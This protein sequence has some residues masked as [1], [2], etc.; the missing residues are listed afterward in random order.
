MT[1]IMT[2]KELQEERRRFRERNGMEPEA[3]KGWKDGVMAGAVIVFI[4]GV[5]LSF[6]IPNHVPMGTF[7][8][9]ASWMIPVLLMLTYGIVL[10]IVMM[11]KK[12][13]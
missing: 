3:S 11:F 2:E 9:V 12:K 1:W 6:V 5:I 4:I 10:N 7:W 8:Y 13:D